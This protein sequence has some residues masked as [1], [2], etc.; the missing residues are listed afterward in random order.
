MQQQQPVVRQLI[1]F[2]VVA[3]LGFLAVGLPLPTF[4]L[5]VPGTLHSAPSRWA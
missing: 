4:S 1:P 3:F 2:S 5:Y